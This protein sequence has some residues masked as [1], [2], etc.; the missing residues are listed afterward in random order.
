MGVPARIIR[1]LRDEEIA[2]LTQSSQNYV[3]DGIEYYGVMQGPK[4]MGSHQID[5]QLYPQNSSDEDY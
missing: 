1:S 4:K 3:A 2:F 5:V